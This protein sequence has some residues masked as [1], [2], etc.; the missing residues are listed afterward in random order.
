ME[1]KAVINI[2][3]VDDNL[4]NAQS[5]QWAIENFES[6][7]AEYQITTFTSVNAFTEARR[8]II[9]NQ[10]EIGLLLVDY[11]LLDH[12][13]TELFKVIDQKSYRIYKILHSITDDSIKSTKNELKNLWYDDFCSSK[14]EKDIQI[15]LKTFENTILKVKLFGNRN[16]RSKYFNEH[17]YRISKDE[18]EKIS[19]RSTIS[20][21]DVLYIE[22][23]KNEHISVAYRDSGSR[24]L[25]ILNT[26]SLTL[27]Q[28]RKSGLFF[29]H[30][31]S[32]LLV[33]LLWVAKIDTDINRVK[34]ISADN[35]IIHLD[36]NPTTLFDQEVRSLLPQISGHIPS[37]FL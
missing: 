31:N 1:N 22:S 5:L 36:F 16:F 3:L 29:R 28:F 21:F 32:T 26:T 15:A 12:F 25:K 24:K 13:G 20:Y 4:L 2:V 23:L 11:N 18:A 27:K 10:S 17:A 19:T 34:F 6:D 7:I 14:D 8:Y 33:N 30:M 9:G 37:F 35:S